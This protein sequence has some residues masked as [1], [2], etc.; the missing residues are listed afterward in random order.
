MLKA[1]WYTPKNLLPSSEKVH[2]HI[3]S[4]PPVKRDVSET[5]G[6][7]A[8]AFKNAARVVEAEYEWPF[9]SARAIRM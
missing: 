4:V 7:V 5:N 2:D 1:Q 3:R 9:Q 6:D 8:A